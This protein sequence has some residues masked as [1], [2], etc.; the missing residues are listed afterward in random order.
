MSHYEQYSSNHFSNHTIRMDLEPTS[1]SIRKKASL[2]QATH[3]YNQKEISG[4]LCQLSICPWIV[5]VHYSTLRNGMNIQTL[6]TH[7]ASSFKL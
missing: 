6:Y 5:E 1:A 4:Q 2:L 3:T 7:C